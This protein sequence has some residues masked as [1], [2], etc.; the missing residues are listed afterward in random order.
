VFYRTS[1]GHIL[2]LDNIS[3][4]YRCNIVAHERDGSKHLVHEAAYDPTDDVSKRAYRVIETFDDEKTLDR[5][6]NWL[7]TLLVIGH[8]SCCYYN[9]QE[10]EA[11]R[12]ARD[13]S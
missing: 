9:F 6:L 3:E 10:E 4:I 13:N 12:N 1:Q 11:K 7:W 2:N 8:R 5:F